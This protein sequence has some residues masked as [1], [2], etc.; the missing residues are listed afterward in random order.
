MTMFRKAASINKKLKVLVYGASGTGKT[1]L[2]LTFPQVAVIDTEGGTELFSDRFNFD[3]LRTKDFDEVLKAIESIAASD[4]QT[5][6]VD[7]ITVLWQVLMESGQIAAERRAV[8]QRHSPD[9]ATLTPRDWG[10]IKRKV[11]ALYTRLVNMPTH[12]VVCG[13]IKDVNQ[14]KGNEVVKVGERVD[15]EK[16]TEYLFDIVIKL[17]MENGKRFGIIEKDRSGKLQGKRIENPSFADFAAVLAVVTSGKETAIAQ[18][19]AQVAEKMAD[20]F[21]K[22]DT[23]NIS[24]L[25]AEADAGLP[26][27]PATRS[28]M[29]EAPGDLPVKWPAFC[30]L[31]KDVLGYDNIPH[32]QGALHKIKGDDYNIFHT[33]GPDSGKLVDD[34]ATVWGWL[35]EYKAQA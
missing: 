17:V 24:A 6:V 11:N 21:D 30:K 3:V 31:A 27:T 15:A 22:K 25:Q 32:I 9:E 28:V 34:P 29:A 20:D 8:K 19:E 18:D 7:P 1:H 23:A 26:G 33:S 35:A 10:T 13:R 16:S 5:V 2:A 4:Y 14:K 12:V